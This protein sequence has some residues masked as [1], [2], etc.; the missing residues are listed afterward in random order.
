MKYKVIR[1]CF[2]KKVYLKAGQTIEADFKKGT[3][4]TWA[5]EIKQE[6]KPATIK[7]E[8]VKEEVK[9][10]DILKDELELLKDIAIDHNI[11]IDLDSNMPIEDAI[12]MFKAELTVNG[13]GF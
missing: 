8:E 13:I 7:K 2:Y 10:K 11:I 9:D 3:V 12:E 4:P 6:K 1:D 5:K